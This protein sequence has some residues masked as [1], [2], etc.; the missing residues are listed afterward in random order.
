MLTA[1]SSSQFSFPEYC[2]GSGY[3]VSDPSR[4]L[5]RRI[6]WLTPGAICCLLRRWASLFNSL[7]M[8]SVPGCDLVANA[9]QGVLVYGERTAFMWLRSSREQVMRSF[10]PIRATAPR[11]INDSNAYP[12]IEHGTNLPYLSQTSLY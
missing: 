11:H 8:L 3:C 5:D 4:L 10:G 1:P 7:K 2:S 6:P 12:L 9:N